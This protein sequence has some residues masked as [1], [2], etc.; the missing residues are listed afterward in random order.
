M[1]KLVQ[2]IKMIR[3]L[4]AAVVVVSA[5]GAFAWGGDVVNNGGGIAEK[6]VIYAYEKLDKYLKT[7]LK[8]DLCK[9]NSQ[10]R[11]MLAQ[12]SGGL[13]QEYK[14]NQLRFASESRTP[15]FFMIDG[16]VRVAKTGNAIGSAI[17]INSDLLYTKTE[18]GEYEAMTIPEAVAV[19]I[20]E[21]GHHYS[22]A[23]HEELD[24]LGVRVS[25]M[26]QLK[27]ST[28]PLIPWSSAI[29]ANVISGLSLNDYPEVI[30]NVGES[31]IDI[32]KQYA[33]V[34][35]CHRMAIPIPILPIPDI[36]L[37][38]RKPA[39]SM[40][41]NV[42]WDKLEENNGKMKVR[43]EANVSNNCIYRTNVGIRN[44]DYKLSISFTANQ[45]MGKWVYDPTSLVINQYRDPW[46][47]II[48]LSLNP[49]Y[50]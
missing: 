37:G 21:L 36:E 2:S 35:M 46:Y 14:S 48:K 30:L 18:S 33:D 27:V 10:Q 20:H 41:Y 43:M 50:F 23:S 3:A 22:N 25:L 39:G 5:S 26:L 15:G 17:Y 11:Y 16:L 4:A 31:M 9:L 8:S 12:I 13:N 42:H 45:I 44:N 49:L 34:V 6:N 47:K 1:R 40:L 24:L 19:L 38:A 29:S 28:T 32:S 7:C